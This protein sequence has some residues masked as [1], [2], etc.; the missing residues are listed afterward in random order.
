MVTFNPGR[1]KVTKV[2]PIDPASNPRKA[3]GQRL[4]LHSRFFYGKR[5]QETGDYPRA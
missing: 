2:Q 1:V 4:Y 3:R 5:T